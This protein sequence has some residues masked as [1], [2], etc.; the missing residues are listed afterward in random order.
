MGCERL[1]TSPTAA[2]ARRM[3]C[4]VSR[5][6]CSSEIRGGEIPGECRLSSCPLTRRRSVAFLRQRKAAA[7]AADEDAGGDVEAKAKAERL[8]RKQQRRAERAE[9]AGVAATAGAAAAAASEPPAEAEPKE[10]IGRKQKKRRHRAE[11]GE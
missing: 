10:E 11:R 8:R 3:I 6:H 4:C 7:G 1:L 9:R 2:L 5:G